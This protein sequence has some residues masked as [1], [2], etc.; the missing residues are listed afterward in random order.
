MTY[1]RTILILMLSFVF[2][3]FVSAQKMKFQANSY[4]A[5]SFFDWN[6]GLITYPLNLNENGARQ[7]NFE[8]YFHP[9]N[10]KSDSVLIFKGTFANGRLEGQANWYFEDGTPK[11]TAVFGGSGNPQ[12]MPWTKYDNY[13]DLYLTGVL[14]GAA[15]TFFRSTKEKTAMI[16][17]LQNF[18]DGEKSGVQKDFYA[19]GQ[20]MAE[21]NFENNLK[22]GKYTAWF[23]SGV[24]SQEGFYSNDL[25]TGKWI[26]Y[27]DNGKTAEIENY[28]MN[29]LTDSAATFYKNGTIRSKSYYGANP[30]FLKSNHPVGDYFYYY[31][32]GKDSVYRHFDWLGFQDSTEIVYYPSGQ[33]LELYNYSY[34]DSDGFAVRGGPYYS[35]YENGK[36]K[37]VGRYT[38]GEKCGKWKYYSEKGVLTNV[39]DYDKVMDFGPGVLAELGDATEDMPLEIWAVAETFP[40]IFPTENQFVIP[41]EEKMRFLLKYEY[42]DVIATVDKDGNFNYKCV[43]QMKPKK[44]EKFIQ[45][46]NSHYNKGAP[47]NINGRAMSCT[48]T[49]RIFISKN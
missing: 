42:V 12:P 2:A 4:A 33:K 19:N 15:V 34:S 45:Y 30:G 46:L 31:P 37:I 35:W 39:V 29:F 26:T 6:N 22:N 3:Q 41:K 47:L 38:K 28:F 21:W 24:V 16:S 1:L 5:R 10:S 17:S 49:M 9:A 7:G 11:I 40:W 25:K 36:V 48:M 32:N 27:F 13:G 43:T 14:N 20:V 8:A 18:K 44:Q 23:Y